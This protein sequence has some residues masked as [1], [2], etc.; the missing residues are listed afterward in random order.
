MIAYS[1]CATPLVHYNLRHTGG[2]ARI[3]AQQ[4]VEHTIGCI[5]TD[6]ARRSP[7]PVSHYCHGVR[8]RIN[9][10]RQAYFGEHRPASTLVQVS[11]LIL[12]SLSVEI[13]AQVLDS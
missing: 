9:P 5:R 7:E 13:E 10:L 3:A 12:P 6:Y 4:F 2:C 1:T 11:G 8:T